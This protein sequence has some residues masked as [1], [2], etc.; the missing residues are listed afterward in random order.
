MYLVGFVRAVILSCTFSVIFSQCLALISRRVYIWHFWCIL[1]LREY[2]LPFSY[3]CGIRHV[4]KRVQYSHMRVQDARGLLNLTRS[5]INKKIGPGPK[6]RPHNGL[7]FILRAYT[8]LN[9]RGRASPH[10]YQSYTLNTI[11]PCIH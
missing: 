8:R 4:L 3:I 9:L 6:L 2:P 5:Q 1:Y 10:T 11:Q 7:A